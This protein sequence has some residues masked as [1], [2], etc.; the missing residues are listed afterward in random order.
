[1]LRKLTLTVSLL[2]VLAG[3]TG[4]AA[5]ASS[6]RVTSENRA[7]GITNASSYYT[8]ARRA[9]CSYFGNYCSQAMAVVRCET[10]GTYY[11]WSR[12]GQYLGIFQMGSNERARYG[13]GNDV[14][15]QARAA[16]RYFVDSGRDWSPWAC[17][18][19]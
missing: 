4:Q 5:Q 15:T 2:V 9:V 17:K 12:N 7:Q 14:W 8:Q 10:G 16:Y 6:N 3:T 19:W 1:M 13:H 18:P 11:P